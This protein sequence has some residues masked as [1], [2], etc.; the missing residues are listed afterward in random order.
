MDERWEAMR[1]GSE[2]FH[3]WLDSLIQDDPD[4]MFLI[5]VPVEEDLPYEAHDMDKTVRF[6]HECP[7]H[8]MH[9]TQDIELEVDGH[10]VIMRGWTNGQREVGLDGE[11]PVVQRCGNDDDALRFYLRVRRGFVAHN[12]KIVDV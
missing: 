6:R 2:E 8:N 4:A 1:L 7:H 11:W 12:F 9:G 10:H 3:R 5:A